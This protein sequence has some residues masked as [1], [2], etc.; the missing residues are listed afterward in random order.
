[1]SILSRLACRAPSKP[2]RRKKEGVLVSHHKRRRPKHQRA[3]CLM[4]KP[5][6]DERMGKKAG[7]KMSGH[8]EGFETYNKPA[9]ARARALDDGGDE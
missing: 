6:K 2:E 7:A 1:M 3:G 5:W 9:I 8:V 4:C